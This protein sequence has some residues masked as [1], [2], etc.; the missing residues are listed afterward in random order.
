MIRNTHRYIK[1]AK[2]ELRVLQHITDT[3]DGTSACIHLK[4]RF[5]WNDH[6]CFVFKLYGPSIYA[7]MLRNGLRPFPDCI[8]RSITYQ[9]CNAIQFLHELEIIHTDLK[10][11]NM[12][13]VDGRTDLVKIHGKTHQLPI[14]TRIKIID[15]AL[16]FMNHNTIQIIRKHG[17]LKMDMII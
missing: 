13:F 14:D 2:K 16:L 5:S 17:N 12:V 8:A 6:P 7:V 15:L 10:T 9:I 11:E 1:A 3:D 4:D